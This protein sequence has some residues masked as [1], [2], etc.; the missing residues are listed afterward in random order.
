MTPLALA[1]LAVT[2]IAIS[3]LPLRYGE[4]LDVYFPR[5]K[6]DQE[7][8][9][10]NFCYVRFSTFSEA[11]MACARSQRRIAGHDILEIRVAQPRPQA[12]GEAGGAMS[13]RD[14]GRGGAR[15]RPY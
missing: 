12:G 7:K 15:Y 14:G 3:V 2:K 5:D 6:R 4:V 1:R 13:E 9:R 11:D 10:R 8:K